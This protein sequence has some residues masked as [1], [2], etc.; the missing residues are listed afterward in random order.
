MDENQY[1]DFMASQQLQ[2]QMGMNSLNTQQQL[3][4]N[5]QERGLAEEQLDVEEIIDRIYNL[6]Q[7]RELKDNGSGVKDWIESKDNQMKILSDWGVQR[8]MQIVRFHINKNTLLSNFDEVQ[9]NRL[10]YHFTTE[11]NDLVLLKYQKLFRETTFEECKQI[12]ELKLSENEKIKHFTYE[13]I[14]QSPDK[15]KIRQKLLDE[16]EGNIEKQINKIREDERKNRIKEYGLL[17]WEI[18]QSVY[19]TLN[20]AYGGKERETLRRHASFS[21][22]RSL[23]PEQQKKGGGVFG[24][25]KS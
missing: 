17:L 5:E 10:M 21:E 11:M 23:Q 1:A 8:I 4:F 7:G 3:M 14:G 22:V 2:Q 19:S 18:E 6:L 25:L 9:I 16:L 20:R 15:E 24:W 13:L 12:M